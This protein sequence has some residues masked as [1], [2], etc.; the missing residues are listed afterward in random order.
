MIK[1]NGKWKHTPEEI[2]N[3]R[4]KMCGKIPWNKGI[5]GCYS[6]EQIE[7][8]SNSH[9]GK[10]SGMKGKTQTPEAK[11]KMSKTRT[12]KYK[13]ENNPLYGRPLSEE[14]AEQSRRAN[15]GK[16]ASPEVCKKISERTSGKNHPMWGKHHTSETIEKIKNNR[17]DVSGKNNPMYGKP[18]PK[19]TGIGKGIHYASPYQGMIWLRSSYELA[20]A[21]Y[22]DSINKDW[23]Y[24]SCRFDLD[25][26]SYAPD[27][28]LIHDDRYIEVKGYMS[29]EAQ[30]KI[31]KT[32]SKYG[33]NLEVLFLKNLKE[34]G[35]FN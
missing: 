8:L 32:I 11:D 4:I 10:P 2:E 35:C 23:L 30:E 16:K 24:E 9:L 7:N 34:L 27:F 26:T 19:G 1:I 33:I 6:K 5:V 14:R 25:N 12:G 20:Y 22:L 21:K 15:L 31:D 29:P 3:Q 28:Y 13:G 18:A 17:P